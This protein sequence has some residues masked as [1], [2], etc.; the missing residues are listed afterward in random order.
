VSFIIVPRPTMQERDPSQAEIN[1][2]MHLRVCYRLACKTNNTA[3]NWG[4]DWNLT[5]IILCRDITFSK[6]AGMVGELHESAAL[7]SCRQPGR[8]GQSQTCI[9]EGSRGGSTVFFNQR[10]KHPA[11]TK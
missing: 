3:S 6:L 5:S 4:V 9:N 8:M 1:R 11:S 7:N 2:Q 10:G